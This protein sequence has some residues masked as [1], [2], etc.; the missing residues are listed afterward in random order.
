MTPRTTF[1]TVASAALLAAGVGNAADRPANVTHATSCRIGSVK[2]LNSRASLIARTK[3]A[4]DAAVK[5]A[6]AHD[7]IGFNRLMRSAAFFYEPTGTRVRI[8]DEDFTHV[9]VRV[10]KA[11]AYPIG[12]VDCSWLS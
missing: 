12:W 9:E 7:N 2:R 5:A 6:I 10:L 11:P 8:L 3:K 1:V 4:Y